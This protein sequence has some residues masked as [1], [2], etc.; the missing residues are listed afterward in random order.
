MSLIYG[1]TWT[2]AEDHQ[3]VNTVGKELLFTQAQAVAE[4]FNAS[5]QT[6]MRSFV[7]PAPARSHSWRFKLP[8]TAH[9]QRHSDRSGSRPHAR[10]PVGE[11]DVALPLEDWRYAVMMNDVDEA[12]LTVGDLRNSLQGVLTSTSKVVRREIGRALFNN[13][14]R[15]FTDRLWGTLTIEPLANGD[16]VLYPPTFDSDTEATADHYL[17]S[18]FTAANIS[19]SNNPLITLRDKIRPHFGFS[20]PDGEDIIVYINKAQAEK[21]EAL[22]DF[23]PVLDRFVQPG[24]DAATLIGTPDIS[25]RILGR[26]NGVWVAEFSEFIPA[27]YMVAVHLFEDRPLRRRVDLEGTGLGDGDLQLIAEEENNPF[28]SMF[29][30]IRFGLGVVNRLNGAVME[31]TTDTQYDVPAIYQR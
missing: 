15:T 17:V 31:L 19:D 11:Y 6:A 7:D 25:G 13:T 20:S 30:R 18:G 12:H 8:G 26:S 24:A 22:A 28:K 23:V 21:I 10:H 2:T 9:L 4:R 5:L 29:W 16:S 3:L 27:N 1:A 14:P